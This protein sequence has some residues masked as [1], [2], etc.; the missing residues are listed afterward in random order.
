MKVRELREWLTV[1]PDDWMVVMA[2]DGEGNGFKKLYS[3][4][5]CVYKSGWISEP[6]EGPIKHGQHA[7]CLWPE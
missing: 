2:K 5:P 3:M 7:I 1:I 4:E 6:A